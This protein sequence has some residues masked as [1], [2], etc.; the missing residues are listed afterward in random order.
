MTDAKTTTD[1]GLLRLGAELACR[2][3]V[4][5]KIADLDVTEETNAAF[6]AARETSGVLIARIAEAPATT[7]A[8]LRV[9]A[10]AIAWFD[11][12]DWAPHA[13]EDCEQQLRDQLTAGLIALA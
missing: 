1:A 3:A 5:R 11:S 6:E 12:D 8:G 9:K 2:M 10:Q 7:L 4:E 13:V